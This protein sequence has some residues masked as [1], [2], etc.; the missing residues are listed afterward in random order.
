MLLQPQAHPQ[1]V[2]KT[3]EKKQPRLPEKGSG[4]I[5]PNWVT[6]RERFPSYD[7]ILTAYR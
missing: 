6:K 2:D 5:W 7:D 1:P 3:G 4:A